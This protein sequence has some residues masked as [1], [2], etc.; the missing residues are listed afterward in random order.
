MLLKK[1]LVDPIGKVKSLK[2]LQYD[3]ALFDTRALYEYIGTEEY[4][5]LPKAVTYPSK[6]QSRLLFFLSEI[7]EDVSHADG[8]TKFMDLTKFVKA[9][10][11]TFLVQIFRLLANSTKDIFREEELIKLIFDKN[12]VIK[13]QIEFRKN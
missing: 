3:I 4:I 12:K 8:G 7:I 6:L 10:L 5:D 2:L 1:P 11:I 9:D 13:P